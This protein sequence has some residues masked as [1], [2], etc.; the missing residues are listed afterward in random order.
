MKL[1]IY[2]VIF[3]LFIALCGALCFT[4]HR[5]NALN[6]EINRKT[7]NIKALEG[8]NIE[9]Q[10]SMDELKYSND[11]LNK[12]IFEIVDS[13]DI[14]LRKIKNVH[15]IVTKTVMHDTISIKDTIFARDFKLDTTIVY[16]PYTKLSLGLKFPSD[17]NVGLA[18]SSE[19]TLIFH[20]HRETVNPPKKFFLFRWFQKK[21][22]V[23]EVEVVESNPLIQTEQSRFINIE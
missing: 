22:T 13:T 19:K 12:R 14:K 21:H 18:I 15:Y 8:R 23:T 9:M 7:V 3:C 1:K 20:T 4:V 16:N 11:S 2:A 10:L 5:I 17:I 6:E